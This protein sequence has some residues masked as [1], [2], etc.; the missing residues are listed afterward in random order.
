VDINV[1]L[2]QYA[3]EGAHDQTKLQDLLNG[4]IEKLLLRP[5]CRLT[6]TKLARQTLND[7]YDDVLADGLIRG[8]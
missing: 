2:Y 3:L 7:S 8:N 1:N 4:F 6:E 5:E